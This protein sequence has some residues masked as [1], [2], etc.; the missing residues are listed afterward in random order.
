VPGD[1]QVVELALEVVEVPGHQRHDVDVGARGRGPLV[2]ADLRHDLRRAG[3]GHGGQ[4][5]GAE[6]FQSA[7][8][9][10]VAV[11]VQETDRDGLDA[12]VF[13][14]GDGGAGVRL[15]KGS[16]H[17]AVG[18]DALPDLEPQVA[19]H[20]RRRLVDEEVVHVV[21][22]LA[23]DLDR[24]AEARRREKPRPGALALDERVGG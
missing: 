10:R 24:V 16:Q 20:Q 3:H 23:P 21:A 17:A 18:H 8:V 19:R 2:L 12:G 5:F 7:L 4:Q 22:A 1:A 15:V 6:V 11:G 14:P 13:E 9:D